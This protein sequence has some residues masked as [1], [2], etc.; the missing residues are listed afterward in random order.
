MFRPGPHFSAPQR[1]CSVRGKDHRGLP[2]QVLVEAYTTVNE[3][4]ARAM[5]QI[6]RDGGVPS[7]LQVTMHEPK[8]EWTVSVERLKKYASSY[9]SGDNVGLRQVERNVKDFLAE[10]A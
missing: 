3:A 4:A 5:E 10:K 9:E 7:D 8:Q 1:I 6:R 2:L